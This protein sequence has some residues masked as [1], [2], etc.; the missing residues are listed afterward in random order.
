MA[1]I[2]V[3]RSNVVPPIDPPAVTVFH[4]FSYA[5]PG[6]VLAPNFVISGSGEVAQRGGNYLDHTVARGDTSP[7]GMRAKAIC[8]IEEIERRMAGL[9]VGWADT[10][11]SQVYTVFDVH[12]YMAE[13]LVKRGPGAAASPGISAGRR[14][15]SWSSSWIAAASRRRGCCRPARMVTRLPAMMKA[16]LLRGYGGFDQLEYREDVPVPQA[17]AGEVLI[18]V[19]AAGVNNTDI[20]TAHR[21]VLEVG[22][23]PAPSRRSVEAGLSRRRRGCR[24]GGRAAGFPAIQGADACGRIVALG[25]ASTRPARRARCSWTRLCASPPAGGLRRRVYFGSD[26]MAR[27]PSMTTSRRSMRTVR[28]PSAMPSWPR[29]LLLRCGRKHVDAGACRRAAKRCWSP[30]RPA[31]SV[32][33]RC[34]SRGGAA[35]RSWPSRARQRRPSVAIARRH[36]RCSSRDADLVEAPGSPGVGRRRHRRG[37]RSLPR[38]CSSAEARRPL[39]RGRRH[40]RADRRARPAHAVPQGSAPARLHDSGRRGVRQPGAATSSAAR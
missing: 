30:G 33:P 26:R 13:D 8:V 1:A 38:T 3:A 7:A 21:L 10:T 31:A 17:G 35:R 16:V 39:R 25:A 4:A 20:N 23:P 34:S 6:K 40:R 37:R 22:Q 15:S 19:A 27:S 11:D 9:G 28:A 5:R 29:S 36:A 14:W 2:P 24:L 18:R 12:S 32:R